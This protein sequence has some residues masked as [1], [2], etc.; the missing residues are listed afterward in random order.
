M[1]DF[2]V[3]FTDSQYQFAYGRKPRGRG[4]WAFYVKADVDQFPTLFWAHRATFT[5][6]KRILHRQLSD[7]GITGAITAEV[8]T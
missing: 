4:S 1:K 7:M 6:A 2:R 3:Y 5:E 8:G